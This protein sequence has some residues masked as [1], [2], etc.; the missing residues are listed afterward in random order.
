MGCLPSKESPPPAPRPL[1]K[2]DTVK[3]NQN[4]V[5]KFTVQFISDKGL[6]DIKPLGGAYVKYGIA[7]DEMRF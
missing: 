4:V 6:A 5:D 3:W 2:G 7:P 1:R